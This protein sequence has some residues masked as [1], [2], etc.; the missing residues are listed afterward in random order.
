MASS[1]ETRDLLLEMSKLVFRPSLQVT[2]FTYLFVAVLHECVCLELEEIEWRGALTPPLT[3]RLANVGSTRPGFV[4][5][6]RAKPYAK[7]LPSL[8]S[9]RRAQ[10]RQVLPSGQEGPVIRVGMLRQP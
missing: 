5:R 4:S 10:A 9:E 6:K 8:A 3:F 2:R 1:F 7:R